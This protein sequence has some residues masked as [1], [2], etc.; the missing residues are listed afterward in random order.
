MP[1][2]VGCLVS[3]PRLGARGGPG[4]ANTATAAGVR[5]GAKSDPPPQS[6]NSR[7]TTRVWGEGGGGS[8]LRPGRSGRTAIPFDSASESGLSGADGTPLPAAQTVGLDHRR[9]FERRSGRPFASGER[10]DAVSRVGIRAAQGSP[11]RR[12]LRGIQL[13]RLL[14]GPETAGRFPRRQTG[15]R[16]GARRRADFT[17]DTNQQIRL[18]FGRQ[19]GQDR[20]RRR[21]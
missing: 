18:E 2:V 12:A 4:A 5:T 10:I 9:G 21:P 6:M 15:R 14:V 16:A 13:G 8:G 17:T 20:R 1:P 11:W 19:G 3:L 7:I